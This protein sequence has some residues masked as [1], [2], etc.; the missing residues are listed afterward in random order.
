MA[1]NNSQFGEGIFFTMANYIFWFFMGNIYFALM[2]IPLIFILTVIFTNITSQFSPA[3]YFIIVI[4][5]IP[6]G[7]S[8]TALFSVMGK[9]S[10]DKEINITNDFFKAYKTNFTQSLFLWVIEILIIIALFMYSRFFTNHNFPQIFTILMYIF[11]CF[12]ATIGLYILPILS[13]FYMKTKDIIRVAA[14]YFVRKPYV[15]LLNLSMLII[16]SFL[17]IRFALLV[18]IFLS[19]IIAFIIMCF[20]RELFLELE[21]KQ[22][23]DSV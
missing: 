23:R 20:E 22:S 17:F 19:S 5:C 11:I 3:V 9:L 16:S 6:V 7:P 2:N 18:L 21:E 14:Y 4:C 13:R 8:A 10:R 1:N 15:S 12:V